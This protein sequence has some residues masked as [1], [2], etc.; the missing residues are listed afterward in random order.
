LVEPFSFHYPSL[1]HVCH[2]LSN[3]FIAWKS[4]KL[5][6][7]SLFTRNDQVDRTALY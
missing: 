3:L 6:S 4:D 1:L 2:M 7:A 5:L